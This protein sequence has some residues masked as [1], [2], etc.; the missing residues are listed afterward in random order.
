[1]NSLIAILSGISLIIA[2]FL[3]FMLL[4]RMRREVLKQYW[5]P[6]GTP[7]ETPIVTLETKKLTKWGKSGVIASSVFGALVLINIV[8]SLTPIQIYGLIVAIGAIFYIFYSIL[9]FVLL[10]R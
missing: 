6:N 7:P 1:M 10:R 3:F 9:D 8:H 4:I 2:P 5:G